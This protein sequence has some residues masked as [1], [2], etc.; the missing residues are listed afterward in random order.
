[1]DYFA[2]H[3]SLLGI[4]HGHVKF[5]TG[6]FF[7]MSVVEIAKFSPWAVLAALMRKLFFPP[8]SS[9]NPPNIPLKILLSRYV[10]TKQTKPTV[11]KKNFYLGKWTSFRLAQR[12]FSTYRPISIQYPNN[13]VRWPSYQGIFLKILFSKI[14]RD[15]FSHVNGYISKVCHTLLS[16]SWVKSGDFCHW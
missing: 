15:I 5:V 4:C 9:D 6:S 13:R 11:Q 2:C 3:R 1:M 7:E 8:C 14:A 10:R 16:M 12:M